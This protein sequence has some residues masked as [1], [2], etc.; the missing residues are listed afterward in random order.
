MNSFD[1][2]IKHVAGKLSG[3]AD[4]LSRLLVNFVAKESDNYSYVNF[5]YDNYELPI[6]ALD[7]RNGIEDDEIL[8]KVFKALKNNWVSA[9]W[10]MINLRNAH[11]KKV[12]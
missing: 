5:I 8:S 7:I 2:E 3:N 12:S 9:K 6:T 10:W 4:G 1:F 11:Q